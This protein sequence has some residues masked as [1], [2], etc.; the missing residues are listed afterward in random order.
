MTRDQFIREYWNYYLMLEKK[1]ITTTLYVALSEDNFN[2]FSNEYVSQLQLIGSELDVLFKQYC[3]FDLD[4]IKN[5]SH[6]ASSILSSYPE[7]RQQEIEVIGADMVI[8]PYKDW[9]SN[10]A[11]QSL[12]W[13]TAFDEIKHNRIGKTANASLKNVLNILGALFLIEMKFLK[14]ISAENNEPDIPNEESVLFTLRGWE[15]KYMSGG[16]A[17]IEFIDMASDMLK[18]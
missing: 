8:Q 15:F 5:I 6:Y 16:D 4:E 7:I 9:D 10:R 11:K 18:K 13:W 3:G 14:N 12:T 1:F 2:T 17:F